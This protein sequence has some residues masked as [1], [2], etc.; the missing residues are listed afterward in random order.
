[1]ET[2]WKFLL[3]V[4]PIVWVLIAMIGLPLIVFSLLHLKA[5]GYFTRKNKKK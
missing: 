4:P 2:I 1:M 5:Y 3:A